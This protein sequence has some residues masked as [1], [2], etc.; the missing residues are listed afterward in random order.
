MTEK[1]IIRQAMEIRGFT[2]TVM[3]EKLGLKKQSSISD[4]LGD[5]SG[6]LKVEWMVQMLDVLGYDVI[7]QDRNTNGQTWKIE[8]AKEE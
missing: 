5:R 2:Q 7:V 6:S 1:E 3:A 4:K 8:L